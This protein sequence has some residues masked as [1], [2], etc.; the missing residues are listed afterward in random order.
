M[1]IVETL[2]PSRR[3]TE[4]AGCSCAVLQRQRQDLIR[5][6]SDI[7]VSSDLVAVYDSS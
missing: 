5:F 2:L 3:N 1:G 7:Y 4:A 6:K